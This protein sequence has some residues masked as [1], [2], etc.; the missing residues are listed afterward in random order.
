MRLDPEQKSLFEGDEND[1]SNKRAVS[2]SHLWKDNT[3]YYKFSQGF[4]E[5][6]S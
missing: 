3:V 2:K 6:C 5:Y 4:S 1:D